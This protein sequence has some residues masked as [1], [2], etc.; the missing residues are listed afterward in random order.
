MTL[1][2]VLKDNKGGC[3]LRNNKAY[4]LIFL[5]SMILLF[6]AACNGTVETLSTPAGDLNRES[7]AV[8]L[9]SDRDATVKSWVEFRNARLPLIASIP[10]KNIFLYGIYPFGAV[11]YYEKSGFYYN[12][13]SL[14][15][16]FDLPK[17]YSFD[18]DT[19]NSREV[20]CFLYPGFEKTYLIEEIHVLKMISG[21]GSMV[22]DDFCFG[23]ED[24]T[25]SLFDLL[26]LEVY[27]DGK[28]QMVDIIAGSRKKTLSLTD[29]NCEINQEKD[30][31]YV[32]NAEFE[33]KGESIEAVFEIG[34]NAGDK[35]LLIGKII[36]DVVFKGSKF[37][38]ANVDFL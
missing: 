36:A 24:Y 5:I 32:E 16:H 11:L 27:N 23:E 1:R 38:L 10:E 26:D 14:S 18:I 30:L 22:M 4:K 9:N 25:K 37:E 29:S 2:V 28:N 34:I 19:D 3:G 33:V 13:I 21:S 7:P 12:W 15:E 6:T 8:T 31:L 20:L 17:L 35:K